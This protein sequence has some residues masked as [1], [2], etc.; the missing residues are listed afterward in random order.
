M[1]LGGAAWLRSG[2]LQ[3]TTQQP[4]VGTAVVSV[5]GAALLLVLGLR[6]AHLAARTRTSVT[7]AQAALWEYYG[8]AGVLAVLYGGLALAERRFGH[9]YV[10]LDGLLLAFALCF[11]L[12]LREAYYNATLSNAE[13]DRFGQYRLRR[14][15]EFGF[16]ALVVVGAIG[17][18]VR[19]AAPFDALLAV[20][21][22]AVVSYGGYFQARRVLA[23]STR[24][25]LVDALTRQ[26]VPVLVFGGGAVA[27]P[28][29]TVVRGTPSGVVEALAASLV[30]A[31]A[32]SLLAITL[33][34]GQ[35]RSTH[36]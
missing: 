3:P 14:S 26:T 8:F 16:V 11:A 19:P 33:K 15:L 5:V 13:V 36:R 7:P 34:L 31:A 24:G 4:D 12:A 10:F 25:T 27:T 1:T 32:A 35:H 21:G 22:V 23:T 6:L 30:L 20:A 28:A 29:L 2:P 18:L 9:D 17:P